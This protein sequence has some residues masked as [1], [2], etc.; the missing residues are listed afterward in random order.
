MAV[1][2]CVQQPS[3]RYL[4]IS[5]ETLFCTN[6][7]LV[8]FAVHSESRLAQPNQVPVQ[9]EATQVRVMKIFLQV[10]FISSWVS[11]VSFYESQVRI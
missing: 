5:E 7:F 3:E 10:Y 9:P 6:I 4:D 11:L 8:N 2:I 1:D